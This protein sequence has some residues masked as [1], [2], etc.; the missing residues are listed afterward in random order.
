MI[1][2]FRQFRLVCQLI[3]KRLKEIPRSHYIH[4]WH[5]V[6]LELYKYLT[7]KKL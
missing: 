5:K 2:V 6:T 1:C 3:L 7:F 4:L